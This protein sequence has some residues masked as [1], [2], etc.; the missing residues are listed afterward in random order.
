MLGN[1]FVLK[2]GH[3]DLIAPVALEPLVADEVRFLAHPEPGAQSQRCLIA[4]I[5][6]CDHTV[7]PEMIK[8]QVEQGMRS[9]SGVTA[10][11]K[12]R[13]KHPPDLAA[14]MLRAPKEE[15]HVP[16]QLSSMHQFDAEGQRVTLSVDRSARPAHSE[17]VGHHLRAHRLERHK[18]ADR[19]KRAVRDQ[20]IDIGSRQRP[21]EKTR[22]SDGIFGRELHESI[23]PDKS[24]PGLTDRL[25]R[26]PPVRF[27]LGGVESPWA[28]PRAAVRRRPG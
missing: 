12:A 1:P 22:R 28:G 17:P 11:R 27:L 7:K 24:R 10:T 3:V 19:F 25:M 20:G 15:H 16:D 9:L 26:G 13:V 5:D 8:G 23:I 21:Q 14:A 2:Q 6:P 18:P 4:R